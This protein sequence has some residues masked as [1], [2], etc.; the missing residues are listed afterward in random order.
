MPR[1]HAV[2]DLHLDHEANHRWLDAL[3][4]QEHLQDYLL[5][6][7]DVS[8]RL[9]VLCRCFDI[10]TSRFAQVFYVPGNHDLWVARDGPDMHSL[11]KLDR[12]LAL[13]RQCGVHTDPWTDGV[14]TIVPLLGWYDHSFGTPTRQLRLA[15]MDYRA[16]RWP[17]PMDDQTIA[18][19]LRA[20][21]RSHHVQ[22]L[23][24]THR[25]ITMSHFMPRLDLLPARIPSA[26]DY[27]HPVLGSTHLDQRLR[28]MGSILHVYGHS[29]INRHVTIDGVTYINNA[30]AYPSETRLSDRV[31]RCIAET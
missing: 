20:R 7:G 9:D 1:I 15:W 31:L 17:Q 30:L 14:T 6:G 19:H 11:D 12:V 29:H 16:C 8:D 25:V 22:A 27:L 23:P 28:A 3:P 26:F 5:V 4:T 10:L 2:S 18:R 13:A 24:A 21:C